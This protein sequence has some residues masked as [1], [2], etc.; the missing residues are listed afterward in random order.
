MRGTKLAIYRQIDEHWWRKVGGERSEEKE[1][2]APD[3]GR[4]T[5]PLC[6]EDHR[7]VGMVAIFE[8]VFG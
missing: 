8:F 6:K 3:D 7:L 2:A 1:K 5:Q 4:L